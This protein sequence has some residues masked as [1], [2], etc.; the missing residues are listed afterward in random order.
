MG[1]PAFLAEQILDKSQNSSKIQC[2]ELEIK[3]L[4]LVFKRISLHSCNKPSF[5]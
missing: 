2:I 3:P 4:F 1:I 5:R